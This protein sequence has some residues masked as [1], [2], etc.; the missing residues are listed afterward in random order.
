MA[1]KLSIRESDVHLPDLGIRT[2]LLET[3]EMGNPDLLLLH[4]NP[5]NADEWV[6]L[7]QILPLLHR[8]GYPGLR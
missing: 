3:G 5:D 4:G 2:R 8:P 1:N 7:M 6:P